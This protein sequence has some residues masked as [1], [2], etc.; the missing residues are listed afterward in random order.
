MQFNLSTRNHILGIFHGRDG[1]LS[2]S[3]I[4][5]LLHTEQGCTAPLTD[6]ITHV[7]AFLNG[8]PEIEESCG[9][10]RLKI[11]PQKVG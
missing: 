10:Y 5:T 4:T 1:W 8:I 3:F 2:S 6:D 9:S 7:E 11:V